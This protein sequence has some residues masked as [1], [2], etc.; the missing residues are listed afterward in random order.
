MSSNLVY[1]PKMK[2]WKEADHEP[3]WSPDPFD[4]SIDGLRGFLSDFILATRG[5]VTPSIFSVWTALFIISS[6]MKRDAWLRWYPQDELYANLFII[7]CGPPLVTGKRL[8]LNLAGEIL[9]DYSEYIADPELSS[10][11]EINLKFGDI[12]WRKLLQMKH[13]TR[14]S[15]GHQGCFLVNDLSHFFAGQNISNALA[16]LYDLQEGPL[17]LTHNNRLRNLDTPYITLIASTTKETLPPLNAE[18]LS[19]VNLIHQPYPTRQ[20]L[21]GEP[22]P[23]QVVPNATE[24]LSERLAW[25]SEHKNGE[26]AFTS[27]GLDYYT[28]LKRKAHERIERAIKADKH[29]IRFFEPIHLLKLSLLIRAQT[30]DESRQITAADVSAAHKILSATEEQ[31]LSAL[32]ESGANWYQKGLELT[33]RK[34][35]QKSP[36]KRADLLQFLCYARIG[37]RNIDKF[38]T[39]LARKGKIAIEL[40]NTT[41]HRPSS[42]SRETYEWIG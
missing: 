37:A 10:E 20:Y 41:R 40:D 3:F 42:S 6:M 31:G 22:A 39:Q 26:Y 25:L 5:I 18:L 28:L 17:E 27:D 34:I 1:E 35:E 24:E 9:H 8:I 13:Y 29:P 2:P 23:R 36:I 38:L 12:T 16:T 11:K 32:D 7:L 14:Y 30:Y 19:R 21:D 4:S 33:R 15:L